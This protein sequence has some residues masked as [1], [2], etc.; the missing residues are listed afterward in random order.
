MNGLSLVSDNELYAVD[1]TLVEKV[2]RNMSYTPVPAAPDAVVGIANLKG[3]IVTL[4][5]LADLLGRHKSDNA[6]H[7]VIFKPSGNEDG[8]MGLLVDSPG[9]LITIDEAN[10]TPPYS[11]T[12]E[13]SFITGLAEQGEKLFRILNIESIK[14]KFRNGD[15]DPANMIH[16][17]GIEYDEII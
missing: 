13:S 5:S 1:V 11:T 2:A 8:Q 16:Q 14:N 7:A 10:I 12:E 6:S 17:G 4:L 9:E 15:K 3:G